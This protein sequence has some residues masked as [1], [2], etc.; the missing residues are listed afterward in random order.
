ME[1]ADSRQPLRFGRALVVLCALAALAATHEQTTREQ[2]ARHVLERLAYG[3]APGDLDR[4]M[5]MGTQAWIR[6]QLHPERIEMP[7]DLSSRLDRLDTQKLGVAALYTS[8]GPPARRAAMD[9]PQQAEAMR[10]RQEAVADEAREARLLR[11][12]Y[13]PAQLQEV[14]VDF[15][16][17]HFNVFIGK[18]QEGTI[19]TGA[20]ERDAIRPYVFA[21]FRTLLGATAHHPEML[22]YLDNWQSSGDDPA[23]KR[24]GGLN[25]NYARELM[26]LHT[27]GVDGGYTQHDVTELARILTGWTYNAR[28]FSEHPGAPA[29][30]FDANR[31]DAGAK[32]FLGADFPA[33]GGVDE[34]ERALDMLAAHPATAQHL[35]YELARY[36]VA[37]DPPKPLVKRLAARYRA[38]DGDIREVL[39]TLFDSPEFWAPQAQGAKFKTPLQYALSSVRALGQPMILDPRPLLNQLAA[40]GEPLYGCPTP[41]GYSDTQAAWLNPDGMIYRL[42]LATALGAGRLPLWRLPPPA[43]AGNDAAMMGMGSTALPATLAPVAAQPL[44]PAPVLATLGD[45]FST[46]TTDTVEAAQPNLRAA[47]LLGSP[48]FMHR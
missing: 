39:Q 5:T 31:H 38:T 8:L 21:R 25:E 34:G 43:S 13:S 48:E 18:G 19:W 27:L 15:W 22:Y 20:Y 40:L 30:T 23:R 24:R 35:A 17:N 1:S 16:F 2:R 12:L 32:Q 29:F 3:P 4:V 6:E 11:A 26:E 47:L 14:M 10:R 45:R 7:P 42:N 46:L 36:F 44:D 37:D 33:G 28:Q 9:D 41:D